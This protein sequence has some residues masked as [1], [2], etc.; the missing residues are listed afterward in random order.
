[1]ERRGEGKGTRRWWG[2][3]LIL[4]G[5]AV[6]LC[7]RIGGYWWKSHT[8]EERYSGESRVARFLVRELWQ[9]ESKKR[10]VL[11]L[12]MGKGEERFRVLVKEASELEFGG[13][14]EGQLQF[15]PFLS[16]RN[17]GEFDER[18]AAKA[19][20]WCLEARVLSAKRLGQSRQV[21]LMLVKTASQVRQWI[22]ERL[23]QSLPESTVE[24]MMAFFLSQRQALALTRKR[25]F[26][27]LGLGH[28]MSISGTHLQAFMDFVQLL[29]GMQ[30]LSW[31]NFFIQVFAL[32]CFGYLSNWTVSV[33]R[34]CLQVG[35]D[36]VYR[37]RQRRCASVQVTLCIA[38]VLLLLS[39]Q[40]FWDLGFYLS[41]VAALILQVVGQRG[42]RFWERKVDRLQ[43]SW[44]RGFSP[45][46]LTLSEHRRAL[47]VEGLHFV[48]S[49][50]TVQV[51][52]LLIL[53]MRGQE[54]H[55]LTFVLNLVLVPIFTFMATLIYLSLPILCLPTFFHFPLKL[56]LTLLEKI[57]RALEGLSKFGGVR[58][59]S[60]EAVLLLLCCFGCLFWRQQ[61]FPQRIKIRR[62]VLWGFLIANG[63][64]L[65]RLIQPDYKL[66]FFDVGQG[67]AVLVEARTGERLLYDMGSKRQ[68][69]RLLKS[70]EAMGINQ[71]DVAVVSHFDED[72][73]G[74]LLP[75]LE[76]V[77]VRR[78]IV[79]KLQFA[80]DG[81]ERQKAL[82][83]LSQLEMRGQAYESLEQGQKIP[84]SG[85]QIE[86]LHSAR[87]GRS[88]SNAGSYVV[89]LRLR[90]K[91]LYLTGDVE[92]EFWRKNRSNSVNAGATAHQEKALPIARY[93]LCP[94]HGSARNFDLSIMPIGEE[95]EVV[96][97]SGIGN[98]YG[99][100]HRA[101]LQ[102]LEKQTVWR[103]DRQSCVRV[104]IWNSWD[105]SFSMR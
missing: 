6:G 25:R 7:W 96:I 100:P 89:L 11:E 15:M 83:Y 59:G 79:P 56:S 21:H 60:L 23:R 58:L 2:E 93:F 66:Y 44:E 82:S 52:L 77:R 34:V 13:V 5:L 37:L 12:E 29:P 36:L 47:L 105:W 101:V 80:R 10:A 35:I 92:V 75:L 72:H 1:M 48:S 45:R 27:Q 87:E 91:A 86:I 78:C 38:M 20:S 95:T 41:F 99:H 104:Y 49:S 32:V 71:L 85:T 50:L 31:R 8:I 14:Y 98:P 76:Q 65:C 57:E 62:L 3:I 68:S 46:L 84:F 69:E 4:L 64:V 90:Q 53:S 74:G 51:V 67:S 54:I 17:P 97:Q 63:L 94:H 61:R 26:Y 16:A 73:C 33:Q 81:A 40:L 103:T 22:E 70:L 18:G 88:V 39:P 28:L 30:K 43:A 19:K 55:W 9:E 24:L 102:S 42:R